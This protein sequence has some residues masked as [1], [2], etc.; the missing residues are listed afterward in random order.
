VAKTSWVRS[1]LENMVIAGIGGLLAWF[2]GQ[3]FG[4][5]LG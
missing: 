3:A 1:G 5:V 4:A 2:I